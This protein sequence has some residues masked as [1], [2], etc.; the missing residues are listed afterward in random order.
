MVV[1]S[2]AFGGIGVA[3]MSCSPFCS[4]RP[5]GQPPL[6]AASPR[7]L[8]Y[9]AH[10]GNTKGLLSSSRFNVF[11]P[12]VAARCPFYTLFRRRHP[13]P[14]LVF[15]FLSPFSSRMLPFSRRRY[16]AMLLHLLFA[17]CRFFYRVI[18]FSRSHQNNND[19]SYHAILSWL[20]IILLC[21]WIYEDYL[22]LSVRTTNFL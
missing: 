17:L 15:F 5:S 22:Q 18:S 16:L 2:S 12:R 11:S 19:K 6:S 1:S 13:F 14:S 9:N 4:L 3:V 7:E 8:I 20:I 21:S 10:L